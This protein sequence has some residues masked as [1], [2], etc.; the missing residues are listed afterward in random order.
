MKHW[1]Y[2]KQKLVCVGYR[3]GEIY[4]IN[5]VES[6]ETKELDADAVRDLV[7]AGMVTNLTLTARNSIQCPYIEKRKLISFGK[8][9]V[10]VVFDTVVSGKLVGYD[11]VDN[12]GKECF[13]D[14]KEA[15]R[16]AWCGTIRNMQAHYPGGNTSFRPMG[17]PLYTRYA[18]D[19]WT[20]EDRKK[21]LEV[22]KEEL[23]EVL[24]KLDRIK[25]VQ[26]HDID[27]DDRV[28]NFSDVVIDEK[29]DRVY[30]EIAMW[31]DNLPI[32]E[33]NPLKDGHG[34]DILPKAK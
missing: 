33:D 20:D 30:V 18:E 11:A 6:G 27:C 4:R 12:T 14:R 16:E 24:C 15:S 31:H 13:V 10:G 19:R 21:E 2:E 26:F 8:I 23:I 25:P 22:L 9:V 5:N 1:I 32:H 7:R 34:R 29:D 17:E 28:Y 3:S